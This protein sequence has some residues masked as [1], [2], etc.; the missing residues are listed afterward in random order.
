M[1]HSS[2]DPWPWLPMVLRKLKG[3][4]AY[5]AHEPVQD[6]AWLMKCSYPEFDLIAY[7]EISLY[8]RTY[9]RWFVPDASRHVAAIFVEAKGNIP[10]AFK[11]ALSKP[12]YFPVAGYN[13]VLSDNNFY[14]MCMT[15]NDIMAARL[16]GFI[17]SHV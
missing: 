3:P 11:K 9:F 17:N 2:S 8:R 6:R 13:G 5:E 7:Y 1:K 10:E 12:F 14:E 4:Y 15:F 16:R